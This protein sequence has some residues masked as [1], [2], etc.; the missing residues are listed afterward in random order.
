MPVIRGHPTN[1]RGTGRLCLSAR[2]PGSDQG[3]CGCRQ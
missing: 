3:A 1:Q 2:P